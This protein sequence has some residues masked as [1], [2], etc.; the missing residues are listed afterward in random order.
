MDN[1]PGQVD[2][3]VFSCGREKPSTSLPRASIK[4]DIPWTGVSYE[5]TSATRFQLR[6]YR[7]SQP[8]ERYNASCYIP[9]TLETEPNP[10]CID[11]KSL[12]HFILIAVVTGA[13]LD[14]YLVSIPL[15]MTPTICVST[16]TALRMTTTAMRLPI[17]HLLVPCSLE[18]PIAMQLSHMVRLMTISMRQTQIAAFIVRMVA[19]NVV[20]GQSRLQRRTISV[21]NPHLTVNQQHL[22]AEEA[23]LIFK[24][25]T[26]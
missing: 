26:D 20:P 10:H 25:N 24:K 4:Y 6:Q 15:R 5:L 2:D 14:V 22:L 23:M 16:N 1:V 19:I 11:A 13:E 9:P 21:P 17:V 7:C 8:P 18:E 3:L 12:N